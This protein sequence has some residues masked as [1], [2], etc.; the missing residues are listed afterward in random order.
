MGAGSHG[1][2]LRRLADG[3][4]DALQRMI[5]H[6]HSALVATVREA[7]PTRYQQRVEPEDVLQETYAAA[8]RALTSQDG[9]RPGDFANMGHFYKWLEAI[10]LN[11][12]R[13]T[14]RAQRAQKRDIR[15]DRPQGPPLTDSYPRLFEQIADGDQTPSRK[16]AREE[17]AAAIMISMARLSDDQRLVIRRRFLQ[18]VPFEEI[19]RELGKSRDAVYILCHR[20]LTKLRTLLTS[21]ASDLTSR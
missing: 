19:A 2:D 7:L 4:G 14:E 18:N 17:T 9:A 21:A 11:Q 8:F 20:G 13:D 15:R 6:C 5:V 10:A 16:L 3:D 12:V 1:D